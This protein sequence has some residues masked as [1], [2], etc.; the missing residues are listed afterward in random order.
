[1]NSKYTLEIDILASIEANLKFL[2]KCIIDIKEKKKQLRKLKK[3][4]PKNQ[5]NLEDSIREI[6]SS[7]DI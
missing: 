1:M 3:Q 4:K 6:E 5:I 2:D 7:K